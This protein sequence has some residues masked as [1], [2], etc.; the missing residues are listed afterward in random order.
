MRNQTE[1]MKSIL[2]SETAQK[3]IDYVA[4]IY[5]N[6]YVGLWIFQ[7]VGSVLDEV[8]KISDALKYE[9]NPMTATMLLD[10][11]EEHY[12]LEKG[13]GL[14]TEQRRDRIAAKIKT[15]GP[16]NPYTL[17]A[18][19]SAALG[20]VSVE[21]V[22]NTGKNKF[23]VI[24]TEEVASLTPA[25]PVI[26]R[27]KPAHLIYDIRVEIRVIPKTELKVAVAMTYG[28]TYSLVAQ[29]TN[30]D[31]NPAIYVTGVTL[32]MNVEGVY[33]DGDTLVI[34]DSLV[35]IDGETLIIE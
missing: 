14:T 4:P 20:G 27:M 8:C 9:T 22:E 16:C 2:T 12:K 6:S 30:P 26:E 29:N 10:Y 23:D 35:A 15:K 5:G 3:M 1:L 33:V 7:A 17:A 18:A 31:P 24:V 19:V 32:V 34:P 11:W 13:N 21:I 28:E 25:I